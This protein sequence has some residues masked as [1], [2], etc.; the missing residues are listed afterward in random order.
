ML[1]SARGFNLLELMVVLIIISILVTL[2]VPTYLNS[3]E[4]AAASEGVHL[5][6][7]LRSA[8]LRYR[9]ECPTACYATNIALLDVEFTAQRYFTIN[10]AGSYDGQVARVD[11]NNNRRPATFGAYFLTINRD[12]QITCA[13]GNANDCRRVQTW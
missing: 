5:L 2:A 12:G 1:R 3:I 9:N 4:K 6:G 7:E 10:L 13:G 8:Q 11:R